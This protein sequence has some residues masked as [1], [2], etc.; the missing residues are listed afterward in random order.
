MALTG[1]L[2]GAG[3]A[4]LGAGP[5]S[6]D[7]RATFDGAGVA[8]VGAPLALLADGTL[9]GLGLVLTGPRP[10]VAVRLTSLPAVR[11]A[12]AAHSAL[13]LRVRALR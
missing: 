11:V 1:V 5:L 4:R 7:A 13:D 9:V 2:D 10:P 12:V 3:A 6:L 8:R